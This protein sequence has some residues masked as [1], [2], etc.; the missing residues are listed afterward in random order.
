M[1]VVRDEQ[2]FGPGRESQCERFL[3]RVFSGR[4][5]PTR[6]RSIGREATAAI[7]HDAGPRRPARFLERLAAAIRDDV[8]PASSPA[9]PR[10]SRET[11]CTIFRHGA[12]LSTCEVVSDRPG[13]LRLRH[14]DLRR[15]HALAGR[16]RASWTGPGRSPATFSRWTESLLIRYDA[17]TLA[18]RARPAGRGGARP[19][20]AVGAAALRADADPVRPAEYEPGHR[21]AGRL[22]R[23]GPDA[24][25]RGPPGRH[26]PPDVPGGLAPGPAAEVRPAGTLHDHRG[27]D[28]GQRPVPRLRPDVPG[29]SSSG[30]AGSAASWRPNGG[31]SWTR[32][33]PGPASA[34]W[35]RPTAARSWSPSIGSGQG[36]RVVVGSSEPVPADGRVIEGGGIVD[37]RSVRGLEGASR[38][39]PGDTVLAGSTVLA[40]WLRIE[41][42]GPSATGRGPTQIG[43][44]LVAATSPAA[45]P[46]TP[47]L[48][49]EA[50]ADRAVGPTLATAGVGLLVGDLTAAGA[51][52]RPDY[53][54]GPGAGV[55]AG[56]APRRRPLRPPGDRGPHP[57]AFERLA[58][59]DLIVLDDDPT[60][61]ASSWRS[62]ASRPGS[63]SPTCSATPPAPSA[64]WTTT[65]P[66]P[67]TPPAG[68]AGPPPRPAAGRF[69]ARA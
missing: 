64:T 54:T 9:L 8:P 45:G 56:D 49:A 30:R 31:G 38:K 14:E 51:I 35:S 61:A 68:P 57:D 4:G 47:T 41:V 44:P 6:S 21:G 28:A 36:D 5:G 53:A 13:R 69:R 48:R 67:S 60:S 33:C 7:R 63:P 46:M 3:G 18:R 11:T 34:A 19:P 32:A 55:P 37:E 29:S 66:R 12:L 65:A 20:R 15:D 26:Q 2:I 10:A 16:S 62:P 25:Q 58:E 52:L 43:R 39:R 42:A 23:P 50:F 59:V 27:R 22:R 40:G 1:L 24:A 17:A